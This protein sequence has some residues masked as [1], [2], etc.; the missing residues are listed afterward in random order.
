MSENRL[1]DYLDHMQQA[2]TDACGFV[3]G[4]AS[5]ENLNDLEDLYIAERELGRIDPQVARRILVVR[6]GDRKG[7]YRA[8]PLKPRLGWAGVRNQSLR[9]TNPGP[10]QPRPASHHK[11]HKPSHPTHHRLHGHRS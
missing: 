3:E 4:M 8:Q 7:V 5:L 1:T 11:E 9:L 2:A 10:T 6:I